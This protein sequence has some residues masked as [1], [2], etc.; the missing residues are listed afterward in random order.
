MGDVG[1]AVFTDQIVTTPMAQ[2]GDSGS[3]LVSLRREALGLVS[4]GSDKAS[5]AGKIGHVMNMLKV[6]I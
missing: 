3:L 4:A 6:T 1:S 5:I 2:P